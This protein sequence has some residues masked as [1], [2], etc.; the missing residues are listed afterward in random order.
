MCGIAGILRTDAQ[1]VDRWGVLAEMSE[2]ISHRGPDDHG[3]FVSGPVGLAHR[4]LSIIDLVGGRQPMIDA[5]QGRALV[6]NGELYNFQELRAP[7]EAAGRRFATKSDTEVLLRL[8]N[9]QRFEWLAKLNGIFAFALWDEPSRRLILARDRLGIKPLYY[10]RVGNELLFA[11]EIKSLL[12]HPG[13]ARTINTDRI[14]E[15]LAFR[16]L[17]GVETLFEGIV[18]VPPGHALVVSQ[19]DLATEIVPYWLPPGTTGAI[20]PQTVTSID[21]IEATI[22]EA[23]GRQLISD[24]PVGTYLSGGVD[25]SLVTT[26]V[27]SYRSGEALHT[28]S[29]GFEEEG[30]DES[31][32]AKRVAT[33][34]GAT[35]HAVLITEQEYVQQLEETVRQLDEPLNHAHTVQ[36]QLLSRHAKQFVTV[37]LTGE[38][39]DELFGGYPRL[40]IPLIGQRLKGMPRAAMSALAGV[41]RLL[42]LRRVVKLLEASADEHSAVIESARFVPRSEFD[43]LCAGHRD[44]PYRRQVYDDVMR[45]ALGTV[46]RVLEFDRRTYLPALLMRLDK[47]SM[48]AAVECRV[49]FLDNEVIDLSMRVPPEL[50]IRGRENKIALKRI[51]ARLLPADLVYRRKAGFGTPL[52]TWFRNPRGLGQYLELLL[53]R[54]ARI[55]QYADPAIVARLVDEHRRGAD[56]SEAI[57]SL[58]ALELWARTV[59]DNAPLSPAVPGASSVWH[60]ELTKLRDLRLGVQPVVARHSGMAV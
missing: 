2:A 12:C 50:K 49:P 14:A 41:S 53:D 57:W 38:G 32:Y 26:F 33:Q 40:H 19:P 56:R 51:A 43:R 37:V 8:S 27:Q 5:E 7:L 9:A 30:Y 4:R 54:Q 55:R 24:V 42:G 52:E 44:F 22:R 23:V 58:L 15:F 21:E 31:A 3:F 10:T 16:T 28:F 20:A 48:S 47:T 34:L 45:G 1:P 18:Q 11:S 6:Y 59:V 29:V 46:D 39:A 17:A 60:E 36:L 35:H 25:S 13:V